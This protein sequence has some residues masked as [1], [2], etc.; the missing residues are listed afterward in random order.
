MT[1]TR[2]ATRSTCTATWSSTTATWATAPILNYQPACDNTAAAAVLAP[3]HGSLNASG[4]LK[5]TCYASVVAPPAS[6]AC[7]SAEQSITQLQ[8]QGVVAAT[9]N[10]WSRRFQGGCCGRGCFCRWRWPCHHR[11]CCCCCCCCC[12]WWCFKVTWIVRVQSCDGPRGGIAPRH[13][14]IVVKNA[15]V[16]PFNATVM[17]L[18]CCCCRH[19]LKTLLARFRLLT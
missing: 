6:R 16:R 4:R 2:T 1:A 3:H 12:W 9:A 17:L 15:R 10:R 13:S 14:R 8:L 5:G 19:I 7:N 11:C 18:Q